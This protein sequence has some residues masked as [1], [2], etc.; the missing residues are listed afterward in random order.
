M[1]LELLDPFA[2]YTSTVPIQSYQQLQFHQTPREVFFLRA[3]KKEAENLILPFLSKGS[4]II[5]LDSQISCRYFHFLV[6]R[7]LSFV[8]QACC[9]FPWLPKWAGSSPFKRISLVDI[10]SLEELKNIKYSNFLSLESWQTEC[11]L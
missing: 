11:D 5:H 6:T 2:T 10:K 7:D 4:S 9:L 3:G 1:F 8:I